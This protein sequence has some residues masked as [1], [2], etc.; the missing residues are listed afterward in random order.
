MSAKSNHLY[1][2][3]EPTAQSP[4]RELFASDVHRGLNRF[5]TRISCGAGPFRVPVFD[6]LYHGFCRF[7]IPAGGKIV[8]SI[9]ATSVGAAPL[10]MTN[11]PGGGGE[12][13]LPGQITEGGAGQ[14]RTPAET[15]DI[16]TDIH[17][18]IANALHDK[19]TPAEIGKIN[20]SSL[21]DAALVSSMLHDAYS[22]CMDFYG[23]SNK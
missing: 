19:L 2:R 6:I 8:F 11:L 18:Y 21:G 20:L 12:F 4:R 9:A 5:G 22:I 3:A 23:D 10:R 7:P 13:P 14:G 16:L 17:K 15:K 1:R